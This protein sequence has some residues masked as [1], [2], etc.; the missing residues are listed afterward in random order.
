M[1]SVWFMSCK[2]LLSSEQCQHAPISKLWVRYVLSLLPAKIEDVSPDLAP[3]MPVF[4]SSFPW[5]IEVEG[6]RW[7]REQ[8]SPRLYACLQEVGNDCRWALAAANSLTAVYV[9]VLLAL[10]KK[11]G[12]TRM[13]GKCIL[14]IAGNTFSC[15]A[16]GSLGFG[17]GKMIVAGL[18][19]SSL[20]GT[21]L[22]WQNSR[23]ILLYSKNF[24]PL[25]TK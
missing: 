7:D 12:C 6:L 24:Y 21:A 23:M 25:N 9:R 22:L 11:N 5:G 16:D 15:G 18:K 2:T 14:I 3:Y 13:Y 19:D 20:M 1:V 17:L 8:D 10:G 4:L